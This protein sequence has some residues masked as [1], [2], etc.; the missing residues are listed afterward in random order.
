MIRGYLRA[1]GFTLPNETALDNLT[2]EVLKSSEIE[3]EILNKEQ[4][5]SLVARQLG[6]EYAGLLPADRYA[7]GVVEMTLDATQN[8]EQ[9][10]TKKRLCA[11]QSALFPTGHS[12]LFTITVGYWRKN[13]K[14]PMQVVS[15][16]MGKEQVH[17][18]APH[19]NRLNAEMKTFLNWFNQKHEIDLVL[20]AAIAHLRFLTI[21]PFDDG[22]G[23]IARALTVLLLAKSDDFPQRFYSISVQISI[24]R[25]KHY[26]MLEKTQSGTL[27]ITAWM[28]WFLNCFLKALKV[29]EQKLT[30]VLDKANFWDKHVKTVFNQRQRNILNKPFDGF[31]GKLNTSKWAKINKCSSDTALRD[32]QDLIS[33]K[34][35]KKEQKGG[36]STNYVLK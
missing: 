10:L 6:I 19:S 30:G 2:N 21:H 12:D 13:D 32:I 24:E 36:R 9:P 25:K 17:F 8:Y 31:E 26:E 28:K 7:E 4:V 15:G 1:A 11:W 35:L 5:R 16:P 29:S 23:R 20:K 33:K 3:G 22:N 34:V 14:G 18:E 27:D